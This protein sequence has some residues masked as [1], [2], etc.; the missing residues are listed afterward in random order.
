MYQTCIDP[1]IFFNIFVVDKNPI[2]QACSIEDKSFHNLIQTLKK[3]ITMTSTEVRLKL[4]V[5]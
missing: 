2:Y 3:F 1:N 5:F 4:P